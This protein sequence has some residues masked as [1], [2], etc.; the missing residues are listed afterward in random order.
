MALPQWRVVKAR[1]QLP[2][3]GVLAILACRRLSP[4]SRQVFLWNGTRSLVNSSDGIRYVLARVGRAHDFIPSG[5]KAHASTRLNFLQNTCREFHLG[6]HYAFLNDLDCKELG[7]RG[8]LRNSI[9][10]LWFCFILCLQ[11]RLSNCV[12]EAAQRCQRCLYSACLFVSVFITG[13]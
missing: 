4:H 6:L 2:S 1:L 9:A 10:S 11:G 13:S 3:P 5:F 7:L 8:T 12:D